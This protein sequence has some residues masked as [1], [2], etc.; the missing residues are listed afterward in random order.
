MSAYDA[1]VTVS[2]E[3]LF[4]LDFASD[5]DIP[6]IVTHLLE[7]RNHP[8]SWRCVVTPNVDHL[9]RYAREP[10]EAAAGHAAT[11]VLPDGAPIVWASRLLKRPLVRRL[12]GVDLFAALW[13]QL[14][15]REV[16]TVV[17]APSVDVAENLGA[18]HPSVRCVIAPIFDAGDQ[19]TIDGLADEVDRL[20]DDI[21]AQFVVI[22]VSMPKHH[23]IAN[24]LR[25]RWTEPAGR[26][27][28]TVL[29]V[30]AAPEFVIGLKKRA[31]RWMQRT[32][33]EWLHRLATEPQRL[34]KRYLVDD[35]RFIGLVWQE[36]RSRDGR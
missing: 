13:P 6:T 31:P 35:T 34:A 14:A 10:E 4:G 17:V 15:G 18:T 28:P 30:G 19:P 3:S 2:T 24:A 23:R 29:L 16:P 20:V 27:M 5:S 32:G 1:A 8:P 12:T 22:G 21:G 36:W 7:E 26:S 25:V 9:V 33:M 11:L